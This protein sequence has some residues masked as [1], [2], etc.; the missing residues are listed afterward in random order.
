MQLSKMTIWSQEN[1]SLFQNVTNILSTSIIFQVSSQIIAN[2]DF[3][4]KAGK[5]TLHFAI[6]TLFESIISLLKAKKIRY[7]RNILSEINVIKLPENE[8]ELRVGKYF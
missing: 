8:M 4:N 7:A 2:F 3:I 1:L 5:D 6:T